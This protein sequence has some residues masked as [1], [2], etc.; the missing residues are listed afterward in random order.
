METTAYIGL[1]RQ[2]ALGHRMEV[3][4]N[5]I[6]NASTTGYRAEAMLFEPVPEDAG[7]EQRLFF[8]QDVALVRDLSEGP[9]RPTGNPL[10]LAI[11]GLGYFVV[12][13]PEGERYGRGG[14]SS[15]TRPPSS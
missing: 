8:V 5:N 2:V 15:S 4:A 7:E 1:S 11:R 3:I 12:A 6:A 14:S 13:T 10:D 9:M